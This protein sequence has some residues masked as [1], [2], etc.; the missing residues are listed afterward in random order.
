MERDSLAQ[1]LK[2]AGHEPIQ[3]TEMQGSSLLVLPYGARALGL[4]PTHGSNL[5]WVH[6]CLR[7][8]KSATEFFNT[9]G[10]RNTGG[11]RTWVSPER[12]L[13]VRN[14][15]DPW[16]SYEVTPSVDPGTY[17]VIVKDNEVRLITDGKIRHHRLGRD[18]GIHLE[19]AFR[20]IPNPLRYECDAADLLQVVSYAGFEQ[21]VS[22]TYSDVDSGFRPVLSIWDAI[23]LP[24]PGHIFIP[25]V[26]KVRPKDF[27]EPTG[28]SHLQCFEGGVGFLFDGRERHKIAIRAIDLPAGRAAYFRKLTEDAYTIVIR[29]FFIDPSAEYVDT[30]WDDPADRGYALECHN[31]GGAN[32]PYGELEYHT[33]AMGS[34]TGR[35]ECFDRA[36][37]YGYLGSKKDIVR[38]MSAF[39]G[40]AV[41]ERFL[42][43]ISL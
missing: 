27:F 30:P 12:D 8:A 3:L 24:A 5:F 22:L 28:P 26:D 23:N 43:T 6:P 17:T 29:N 40:R 36:Q 25:T 10:W 37:L 9:S 32:G 7:E 13:H 4:F 19:K 20:L 41:V 35:T 2:G 15:Q 33:P 39:F 16:N 1:A 18:C 14:L 21:I 11:D 31:D 42:A 34:G 38:I